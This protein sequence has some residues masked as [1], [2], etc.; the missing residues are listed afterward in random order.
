ARFWVMIVVLLGASTGPRLFWHGEAVPLTR[1]LASLPLVFGVLQGRDL[2]LQNWE[3]QVVRVDDYVS[4][5]YS[6]PGVPPLYLY[7]GYYSSQRAGQTLHTPR[8][9]LPGSGWQPV[10]AA[11]LK[12]RSEEHTSELQSPC[13]LVCRLLLEKKK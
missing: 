7:I 6:A 1:P 3:L 12:L 4:R 13:N 9:C 5:V 11:E 2:P 8:N 10:T